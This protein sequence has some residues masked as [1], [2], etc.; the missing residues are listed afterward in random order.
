LALYTQS[1]L[2]LLAAPEESKLRASQ[3][4][5]TPSIFQGQK[6]RSGKWILEEEQYASALIKLFEKGFL[7]D[8]ENG[9]TLRSYLSRKLHCPP[10][11]ISKKYAGKG[12]GKMLFICRVRLNLGGVRPCLE[13]LKVLEK[14]A[15]DKEQLFYKAL[16]PESIV[17]VRGSSIQYVVA[18]LIFGAV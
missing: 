14:Q 17:K 7:T 4:F 13:E 10:M 3:R 6:Q 16:F 9:S 1:A 15:G 11:R 12:I 2:S 18:T 8:C 5:S